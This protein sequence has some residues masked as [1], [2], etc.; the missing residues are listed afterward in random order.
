MIPDEL[1]T[2]EFNAG[3]LVE[4]HLELITIDAKS[5]A[6]AKS[7]AAKFLVAM[8]VLSTFLKKLED[9]M[10]RA[11]TMKEATYAQGIAM[12]EGN[13]ITEKKI[14]VNNN[15]NYTDARE[16]NERLEAFRYWIKTHIKIFEQAH[17]L[18]RQVGRD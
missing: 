2:F 14:E 18:F 15:K 16:F 10:A 4:D 17:L 8:S 5:I 3:V 1:K 7:R 9:D 6:D 11:T 13:K 12:I